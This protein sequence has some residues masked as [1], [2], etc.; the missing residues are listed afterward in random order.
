MLAQYM[1]VALI[2][3]KLFKN[4]CRTFQLSNFWAFLFYLKYDLPV[5]LRLAMI[6]S[7]RIIECK[8]YPREWLFVWH[9]LHHHWIVMYDFCDNWNHATETR[10]IF[11]NA[12]KIRRGLSVLLSS[13]CYFLQ[14]IFDFNES[15]DICRFV[16][17]T[18]RKIFTHAKDWNMILKSWH[19][20]LTSIYE[21]QM[22]SNYTERLKNVI[23]ELSSNGAKNSNNPSIKYKIIREFI[24]IFAL[25]LHSRN[26]I[27]S[28]NFFLELD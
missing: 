26:R 13:I 16:T 8:T 22:L 21:M 18:S 10:D 15:R 11:K 23:I 24:L 17:S 12:S 20:S 14:H 1:Y 3:C 6:S 4:I 27:R 9:V 25:L 19:V 28:N 7:H 5:L 2:Y